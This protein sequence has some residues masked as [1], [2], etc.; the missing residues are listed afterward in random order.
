MTTIMI[1]GEEREASEVPTRCS[2]CGEGALDFEFCD[3]CLIKKL[4][5]AIKEDNRDFI[6]DKLESRFLNAGTTGR[7]AQKVGGFD[8]DDSRY[9]DMTVWSSEGFRLDAEE[10]ARWMNDE[11]EF[12]VTLDFCRNDDEFRKFCRVIVRK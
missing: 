7:K 11:D 9:F 6:S 8:R 5:T 12:N 10:L 2:E 4:K 3:M 1:D